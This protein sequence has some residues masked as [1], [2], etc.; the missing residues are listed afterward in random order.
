MRLLVQVKLVSSHSIL[1]VCVWQAGAGRAR[2]GVHGRRA[3]PGAGRPGR[4]R[5]GHPRGQA[6]ALHRAGRHQAAPVPAHH[7][8]CRHRQPGAC[9]SCVIYI[10]KNVMF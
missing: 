3:H 2:G 7:A 9:L 6:V 10:N 4:V 8:G 5:H 1:T